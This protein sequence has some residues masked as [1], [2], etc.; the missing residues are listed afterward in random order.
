MV[1]FLVCA[2]CSRCAFCNFGEAYCHLLQGD[3]F[4]FT[5]MLKRLGKKCYSLFVKEICGQSG[6]W[7]Q[8]EGRWMGL[9]VCTN[10]LLTLTSAS[11]SFSLLLVLYLLKNFLLQFYWL[12]TFPPNFPYKFRLSFPST[13]SEWTRN[14][15]SHPEGGWNTL[16]RKFVTLHSFTSPNPKEDHLPQARSF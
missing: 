3:W 7:E 13:T 5:W 12:T 10:T 1:L 4:W 9:V 11:F 15:V 6:E 8:W 2:S 16:F 14:K